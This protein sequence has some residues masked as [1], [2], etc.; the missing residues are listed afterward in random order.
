MESDFCDKDGAHKIKQKLEE[1]WASR[2]YDVSVDLVDAG[3]VPAMRSARTDVRSN[4]KNGMPAK[5]KK[6]PVRVKTQPSLPKGEPGRI[7]KRVHREY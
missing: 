3:F 5:V 6:L 4:M 1:Y 2:G 7:A